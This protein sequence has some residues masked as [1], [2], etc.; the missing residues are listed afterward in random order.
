MAI[1]PGITRAASVAQAYAG[2][3]PYRAAVEEIPAAPLVELEPNTALTRDDLR[4][5]D[6]APEQEH[7]QSGQSLADYMRSEIGGTIGNLFSTSTEGFSLAFAQNAQF[8]S[9][10]NMPGSSSS[11][12]TI[13]HGISTYEMISAVIHRDLAPRGENV[14]LTL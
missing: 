8:S 3:Y 2:G 9:A 5:S 13:R 7:A 14:S 10:P 12:A 1:S 6:F 4:Y 11:K